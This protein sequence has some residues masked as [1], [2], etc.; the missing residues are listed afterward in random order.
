MCIGRF[1][2][3][4]VTLGIAIPR[5]DLIKQSAIT[6]NMYL[7]N[8]KA[9][10]HEGKGKLGS[11]NIKTLLLAIPTLSFSRLWYLAELRNQKLANL[12][13]GNV[14]FKGTFTGYKYLKLSIGNLLILVVT[15]GLGV[16]IIINRIINFNIKNIHVLGNI[17]ELSISQGGDKTKIG[18]MGE[19]F[20]D[21]LGAD[22]GFDVDF[23]LI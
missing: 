13:F 7:G 6:N 1:I 12:S 15:V 18:N 20:E 16:P 11:V 21:S 4:I 9:C 14:H 10:F 22:A 23:G 2:I 19:G 17:N 8:K 3:N 5:S